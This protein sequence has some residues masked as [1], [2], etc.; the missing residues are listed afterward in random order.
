M[1]MYMSI[2]FFL[3]Y[4]YIV[5]KLK[6]KCYKSFF[7]SLKRICL[8]LISTLNIQ[9]QKRNTY[10]FL[11][12]STYSLNSI[13]WMSSWLYAV[14]WLLIQSNSIH[15]G[16]LLFGPTISTELCTIMLYD[17]KKCT[18]MLTK[19]N[20]DQKSVPIKLLNENLFIHVLEWLWLMTVFPFL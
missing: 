19:K 14:E 10:F 2:E 17:Q 4:Q 12:R 3:H 20:V 1:I 9:F 6:K 8:I 7:L 16:S 15:D 11:S 18:I 5:F 13:A